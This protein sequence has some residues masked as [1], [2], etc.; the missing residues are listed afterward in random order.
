MRLL[1]TRLR[2]AFAGSVARAALLAVALVVWFG[3]PLAAQSRQLPSL[4]LCSGCLLPPTAS[5]P[6]L[7][8]MRVAG[9]LGA[10]AVGFTLGAEGGLVVAAGVAH[11]VTGHGG[12]V[13]SPKLVR[14]LTPIMVAGGAL[15]AGTSAWLAS[16]INGQNSSWGW[17]VGAT[18]VVTALAFRCAG[19]PM[20]SESRKRPMSRWRRMAP[21]WMSALTATIAASATRERR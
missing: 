7:Q 17:D 21:V 11:L 2:R 16:R 6:A 1:A 3:A 20:T 4:T 12:E 18:T 5:T 19:W 15:G 10:S 8:P 13:T 14:A 9:E